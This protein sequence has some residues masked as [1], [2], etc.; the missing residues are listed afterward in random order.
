MLACYQRDARMDNEKNPSQ[1]DAAGDF[2]RNYIID[3]CALEWLSDA[4]AEAAAGASPV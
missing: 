4:A 1:R 2:Y 3:F